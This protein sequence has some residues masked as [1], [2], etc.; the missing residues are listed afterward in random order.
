[1]AY[2]AVPPGAP[3]IVGLLEAFPH[4]AR[5]L[6]QL[7]QVLLRGPST[8][9]PGEREMIATHVSRLNDCT[10]C[11]SAHA[12]VARHL[13]DDPSPVDALGGKPED[14]SVSDKLRALLAIAE[15][16][17]RGGKCVTE[18][19][20]ERA[21]RHGATDLE[22]HDTV[23]IAAAFCMFNRYVDGLGTWAPKDPEVYDSIGAQLAA[24]GYPT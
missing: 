1:M 5:A 18:E 10:F 2:V 6:N 21:R 8:L 16:V 4:T 23:L 7:A 17:Q 19:H 9:T 14:V 12:A 20:I 3:G 24:E 22:I 15:Q 11:A 13:L